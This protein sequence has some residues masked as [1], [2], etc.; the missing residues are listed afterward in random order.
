MYQLNLISSYVASVINTKLPGNP[1]ENRVLVLSPK[2]IN[3]T[4]S[5][6]II[7]DQVKEGVPRKGVV[8]KRGEITEEYRSYKVLTEIGTVITYG[9]YAGKEVEFDDSLLPEEIQKLISNQTFT[10]LSM[11]EIIYAEPNMMD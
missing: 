5:G 2:D 4:K 6:I 11:N 8:I 9:L 10:V 7:P 1:T 3:K